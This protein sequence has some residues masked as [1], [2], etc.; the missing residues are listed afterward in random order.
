MAVALK[1]DGKSEAPV[2]QPKQEAGAPAGDGDGDAGSQPAPPAPAAAGN[3][4]Q[5]LAPA[6]SMMGG[7]GG[8]PPPGMG[9]Y[10]SY[11]MGPYGFPPQPP[12]MPPMMGGMGGGMM[13]PGGPHHPY[14]MPGMMMPPSAGV[15]PS[16]AVAAQPLARAKA[17]TAAVCVLHPPGM[18]RSFEVPFPERK[19]PV[20]DRCKKNYRS[21]ELCRQRDGHKALPWQST[22][23]VVTLSDDVLEKG[24]DGETLQYA[25]IPVAA[26]LQQ[27]PE[28]CRGPADGIMARE[29]ICKVCKE[30]NYTRDHCRNTLHH[31]TPPYQCV[32]VK[33]VPLPPEGADSGRMRPAKRKKKRAEEN[34][35]GIPRPNLPLPDE[36]VEVEQHK[37]DD[38]T[39]IHPSKTFYAIISSKKISVKW[40]EQIRFP[41]SEP[42][43]ASPQPAAASAVGHPALGGGGFMMPPYMNSGPNNPVMQSQ[44]QMWDAFRAGAMW[45]QSQAAAGQQVS[46]PPG[47]GHAKYAPPQ[48]DRD[49]GGKNL[50]I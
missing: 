28:M 13:P 27:I 36:V 35:D 16:A 20:C 47:F 2:D 42:E 6:P 33:L 3:G 10:P 24:S 46:M 30:R 48:A 45:A 26:E 19:L 7:M 49:A 34:A 32:Y 29:P 21:R 50:T 17:A 37:S 22:Y 40:C 41:P 18:P 4:Q 25:D 12:M 8:M 31:T 5:Q 1:V 9:G 23:V 38:L 15:P 11:G 44:Y 14:G 43:E 39:E